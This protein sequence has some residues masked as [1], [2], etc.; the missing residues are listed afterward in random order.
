MDVVYLFYDSKR[1]VIPFSGMAGDFLRKIEASRLG[2]WDFAGWRYIINLE[3]MAQDGYA[4]PPVLQE[5]LKGTPY[6]VVDVS[7]KKPVQVYN[8]FSSQYRDTVSGEVLPLVISSTRS[9]G[10][11]GYAADRCCLIDAMPLPE[12]FPPFWLN[13]LETELRARKY[14]PRTISSYIHYNR[15]FCRS[16]QKRPEDAGPEDITGYLARLD[17]TM[18]LSSSSLN[19]AISALKF[20]YHEV[21]KKNIMNEQRRPRH[22]KRL[23]LILSKPEVEQILGQEKN[24][25]HRLLLMMAYSSGLRVSEV[26][27][28]KQN[29][30]D[31]ERRVVF[32]RAGKGRKDRYTLLSDRAALFVKDYCRLYNIQEWLFPGR[33]EMRHLSIRSAQSIFEKA[34]LNTGISKDVSI[35]SLRHTF[36]THLLEC[37]T[38]IRFIQAILGHTCL[39]T[40]ERYTHVARRS[41]E[42]IQSPL[43]QIDTPLD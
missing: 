39:K 42:K 41:L 8:F 38:D 35:H 25:K 22:D 1:L 2:G 32:V 29:S 15:A 14:S 34:L 28:L 13:K 19:L 33:N 23:P 17:K 24:P 20:F 16:V 3:C 37:G 31:F 21:L 43:D 6:V 40:T 12:M 4:I 18:D 9:R 11:D 27:T 36:A 7:L 30:F 26:V 10:A 5:I